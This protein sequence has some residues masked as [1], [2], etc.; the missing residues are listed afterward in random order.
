M[1]WSGIAET[2]SQIAHTTMRMLPATLAAAAIF[3]VL[4]LWSPCNAGKPWWQKR[5]LGTDLAYWILIP[6]F[7]RYVRIGLTILFT[8]WLLGI[9]SGED[10]I[11]LYDHGH[12][13]LS[14][15]PLWLQAVI[16]VVGS[17]FLLYWSH[18]LFHRGPF[19]KY[20][21]VHHASEDL[22]WISAWR[23][24]PFNLMFGTVLV[25]VAFILAGISTDI[26]LVVG[27]F[28]ILTS[29]MV[30]ANLNW[31]FGPLKS[32]VAS[33][34]FHRWHHTAPEL[35]GMKNYAGTF[36][37]WDKIFGTF[38]MPEGVLPEK[39]GIGDPQFPKGMALQFLYPIL[40]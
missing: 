24:H 39:Y 34:V 29:A 3:S 16:F 31:T 37:L 28:N 25:D 12:G 4:S 13:P 19:W 1:D 2:A 21:A 9:T 40:R 6:V 33:P 26:F 10:M 27:P 23:F 30:H 17:D 38:Y 35:G 7:T 22:E 15:L 36:S 11:R 14:R 5:G 8:V 32:V 20:H 18:R